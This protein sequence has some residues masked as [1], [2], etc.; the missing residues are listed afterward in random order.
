MKNE[1]QIKKG[2]KVLRCFAIQKPFSEY[3]TKLILILPHGNG[4][5]YVWYIAELCVVGNTQTLK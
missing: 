1:N 5:P 2:H 4:K 3:S